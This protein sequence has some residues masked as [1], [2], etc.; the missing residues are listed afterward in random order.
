MSVMMLDLFSPQEDH[1]QW[2]STAH[3]MRRPTRSLLCLSCDR[4]LV[5]VLIDKITA[6]TAFSLIKCHFNFLYVLYTNLRVEHDIYLYSFKET[7]T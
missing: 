2:A 3:H 1:D 7:R 5:W 6:T 4:R